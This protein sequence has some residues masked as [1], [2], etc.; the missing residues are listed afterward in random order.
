MAAG[1]AEQGG[2]RWGSP[3]TSVDGE[4]VQAASGSSVTLIRSNIVAS[5]RT[6][7]RSICV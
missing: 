7:K 5:H 4:V 6:M 2:G 1:G 3:R